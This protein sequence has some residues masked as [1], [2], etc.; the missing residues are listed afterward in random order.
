MENTQE[1]KRKLYTRKEAASY[2]GISLS[3]LDCARHN[4]KLAYVQFV[5]NGGVFFTET[6]LEE[7]IAKSTHRVLDKSDI[8]VA[9]RRRR[10]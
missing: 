5:T 3:T 1:V 7:Y 2:L 4:G 9:C 6:A 10:I 8:R